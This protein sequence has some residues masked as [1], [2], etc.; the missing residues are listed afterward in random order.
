MGGLSED[1]NLI[2][3]TQLGRGQCEPPDGPA[4]PP[5]CGVFAALPSTLAV[6]VEGKPGLDTSA[7]EEPK[8]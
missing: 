7:A 6:C 5:P 2:L 8:L 4:G 1:D 3:T